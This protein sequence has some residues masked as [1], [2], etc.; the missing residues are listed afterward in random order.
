MA[1]IVNQQNFTNA[2]KDQSQ[3]QVEYAS[4]TAPQFDLQTQNGLRQAIQQQDEPT[5][6]KFRGQSIDG[7]GDLDEKQ[8]S[9]NLVLTHIS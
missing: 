1:A 2:I 4:F 5:K 7:K 8:M 3:Y 9:T 6:L